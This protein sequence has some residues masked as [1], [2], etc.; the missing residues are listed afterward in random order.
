MKKHDLRYWQLL[1]MFLTVHLPKHR[2]YGKNTVG[3][4]SDSLR[5]FHRYFLETKQVPLADFTF[6]MINRKNVYAFIN[7]LH[8]G[9]NCTAT[10]I[11][12]RL[13]ALKSF[14]LFA[15][16]ETPALMAI[17]LE[18]KQIPAIKEPKRDIDGLTKSAVKALLKQP[19]GKT[20]KGIRNRMI[21]I[22]LYDTAARIQELLD[23]KLNDVVLESE[24][25]GIYLHGKGDKLRYIPL[26]DKTVEHLREYLRLFHPVETG[27]VR[28]YLFYTTIKGKS[29]RISVDT[30]EWMMKKYGKQA[31]VFCTE[32]PQQVHPHQLR[33]ARAQHLYQDGVPL[34]Y[35]AEFLGHA[36]MTTTQIYASADITMMREA[37]EKTGFFQEN[38]QPEWQENEDMFKKLCGL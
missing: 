35:I 5:I 34:S 7:W 24:N 22:L 17:Y 23:I 10:T 15:A 29:D 19:D 37:I 33:H 26:M 36:S 38:I 1:R 31:G 4:Y 20:K 9:R 21:L 27:D 2:C 25:T 12:L 6:P 32:M 18:I 11:N 8:T 14:L 3:T 30:V 13:A 16:A 28:Q